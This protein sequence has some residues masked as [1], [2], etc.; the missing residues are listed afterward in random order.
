MAEG[1]ARPRATSAVGWGP[2]GSRH[3]LEAR[4]GEA[5]AGLGRVG[6]CYWRKERA[7]SV[8][9]NVWPPLPSVRNFGSGRAELFGGEV[10]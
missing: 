1:V 2:P 10:L 3:A 5:G 4:A 7:S 9:C 8:R 6:R